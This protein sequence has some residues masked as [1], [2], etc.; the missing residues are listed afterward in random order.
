LLIQKQ[1]DD[2]RISIDPNSRLFRTLSRLVPSPN[3]RSHDH[4]GTGDGSSSSSQQDLAQHAWG[5]PPEYQYSANQAPIDLRLNIVIQVVGSRGDVQPFIALASELLRH[6]HRVRIATHDVFRD[7]VLQSEPVD[8]NRPHS[9][10]EFF[11]IGGDPAE[12][13]AYMVKNPGLIPSLRS[14]RAGDVQKKRAMVADILHGCWR[15]CVDPDPVSGTPFVADAIIANPPSFAHVHCAQ[16]LGVPLHLMFTM[17][18]TSTR[19]F[20]HPLANMDFRNGAGGM[21]EGAANYA[22]FLVVEWM[23]WQGL[24]DVINKFRDTLDLEP[25]PLSEGPGLV[26]TLGIPFTYCWSPSLIPK[27]RDWPEF[28]GKIFI[29]PFLFLFSFFPTSVIFSAVLCCTFFLLNLGCNPRGQNQALQGH[30]LTS[31]LK[32][33]AASSSATLRDTH[34][35]QI[36]TIFSKAAPLPST[37]ASAVSSSTTPSS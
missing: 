27:P 21:S 20:A 7:F 8:D 35:R 24:G 6:G 37:S 25:V 33:C 3:K 13:M 5:A 31:V 9:R 34:H 28:I 23:T 29:P 14:L 32:T 11:P 19:A 26:K 17:P 36:C 15:S 2:G 10:L 22:S 12:L 1:T 30:E 16:A 4:A 18:W